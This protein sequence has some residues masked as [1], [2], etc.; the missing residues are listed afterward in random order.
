MFHQEIISELEN[1]G[2]NIPDHIIVYNIQKYELKHSNYQ[3][4][5][6]KAVMQIK[7]VLGNGK[8]YYEVWIQLDKAT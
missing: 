4:I 8:D 5:G 2:D 1:S 7:K 6:E 3:W